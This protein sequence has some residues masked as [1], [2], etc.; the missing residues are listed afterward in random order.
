V[1]D[2]PADAPDRPAPDDPDGAD[3][4]D[5]ET[6]RTGATAGLAARAR[7]HLLAEHRDLFAGVVTAAG[8]LDGPDRDALRERLATAG[9]LDRA[10]DALEETVRALDRQLPHDP[11]PAPPYVVVTSAGLVLRATLE[12][13]RLVVTVAAFQRRGGEWVPA[14]ATPEAALA[15]ELR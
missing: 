4:V 15:V 14:G 2:D 10:V 3:A 5:P 13:A 11:V 1:T 12:D 9:L 6:P 7:A 8:G